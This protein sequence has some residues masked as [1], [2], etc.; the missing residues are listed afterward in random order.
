M[1]FFT[2]ELVG[3]NSFISMNIYLT[4]ASQTGHFLFFGL[5]F[6][7]LGEQALGKNIGGLKAKEENREKTYDL[8]N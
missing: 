5:I 7:I 8:K 1:T 2:K 4:M 3:Y 6:H